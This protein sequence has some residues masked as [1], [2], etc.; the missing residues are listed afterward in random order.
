[1]KKWIGAA[2]LFALFIWMLLYS[3]LSIQGAANGLLLWY[4]TV[5]PS[6]LPALIL[7]KLL[8][9][10]GGDQLLSGIFAPISRLFMKLTSHGT[11]ALLIGLLCGYPA[12]MKTA[13]D[14]YRGGRLEQEESRRLMACLSFPSPM[15][16]TGYIYT[17][18]LAQSFPFWK[19]ALAVYFPPLAAEIILALIF[20]VKNFSRQISAQNTRKLIPV[21]QKKNPAKQDSPAFAEALDEILMDSCTTVV[22][23]GLL[24][25]LFSV[26]AT[27]IQQLLPGTPVLQMGA[28]GLLE[29]TT[30]SYLAAKST[31]SPAWQAACITFFICFG[32]LSV[33]AQSISAGKGLPFTVWQYLFWKLFHGAASAALLLALWYV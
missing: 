10:T 9:F 21:I 24:M 25:M 3:R 7:S 29:M 28:S 31:L 12:G 2:G 26:L 22:K 17:G 27:C 14:L 8:I 30:G 20:R 13:A 18:L 16:L 15:F 32:G 6:I 1:M 11:Y 4:Q 5:L 19:L 33:A 23:I